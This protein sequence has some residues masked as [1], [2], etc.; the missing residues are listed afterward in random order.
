MATHTAGAGLSGLAALEIPRKEAPKLEGFFSDVLGSATPAA[1]VNKAIA[2]SVKGRILTVRDSR[3]YLMVAP[4]EIAPDR[5][6]T[7]GVPV[8]HP[9]LA[10]PSSAVTAV[11]DELAH[12]GARSV[13]IALPCDSEFGGAFAD[14]GFTLG[15]RMVAMS[16]PVT[17]GSAAPRGSWVIYSLQRRRRFAD[18]FY[19]TLDGSLDFPELPVCRNPVMLMKAFESRGVFESEDFALL[20]IDGAPA[21]IML[22]V[23]V[24]TSLEVAYTG[25]VP[26]WRRNG[27]GSVL[28]SRAMTRASIRRAH[29]VELTVD[30]R[31]VP[32]MTLYRRFGLREKRA[33]R[34]YFRVLTKS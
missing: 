20:E 18:V 26:S 12:S 9:S 32:A 5:T 30:D 15:P 34:V 25:V 16:G 3:G 2:E 6:A 10:V 33:V 29:A 17:A 13:H 7:L 19:A 23:M 28:M 8:F 24:S 1:V 14:A 11:V 22:L 31:N 4:F 21:G 27:I